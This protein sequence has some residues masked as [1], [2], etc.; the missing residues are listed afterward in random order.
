[1]SWHDATAFCEWLSRKSGQQVRLPT[2]AEWEYVCRAGSAGV[3][4]WGDREQDAQGKANV[5]CSDERHRGSDGKEYHWTV[6]FKH[7]T[8]GHAYTAPVGS[9][10]P[11]SFGL[12]DMVGNVW[13]WC[14]DWY[15]RDYYRASPTE[16]PRGA[17][18]GRARVL[19]GGSWGYAPG[20]CRSANR[21][22]PY[23]SDAHASAGFRVVLLAKPSR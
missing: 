15:D 17:S 23:P 2:E 7:V 16:N 13:E 8:D 14:N 12:R 6:F 20:N 21:G 11:N 9:F 4:P 1:M 10:S 5:T 18:N 19:R 3:F 22:R